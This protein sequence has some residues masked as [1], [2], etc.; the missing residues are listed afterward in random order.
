MT[1]ACDRR[2]EEADRGGDVRVGVYVRRS[3]DDV[4]G[5]STHRPGLQRAL[6]AARAGIIDV[7]L[8]YRSTG[9]PAACAIS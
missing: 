1:R 8:V 7:L 2:S 6:A 9:S 3:T 4:S 5:A